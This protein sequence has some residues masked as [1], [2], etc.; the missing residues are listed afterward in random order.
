MD[1]LFYV[2]SFSV[3]LLR[4]IE[5]VLLTIANIMNSIF[6]WVGCLSYMIPTKYTFSVCRNYPSKRKEK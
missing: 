5:L 6:L 2:D 3:F 1:L 4:P